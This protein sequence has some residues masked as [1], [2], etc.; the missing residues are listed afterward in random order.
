M[1]DWRERLTFFS[2]A[3]RSEYS[4][5]GALEMEDVALGDTWMKCSVWAHVMQ[6]GV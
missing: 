3:V 6:E 2:P 1:E 5:E 4:R